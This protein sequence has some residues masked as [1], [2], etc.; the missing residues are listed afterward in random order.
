MLR[1][2]DPLPATLLLLLLL[3]APALHPGLLAAQ[4]WEVEGEVGA[5]VFFGNTDQVNVMTRAAVERGDSILEFSGDAGFNYGEATDSDGLSSV[6]KRSWV[7]RVNLDYRPLARVS[8]FFFAMVESS[9]EKRLALRHSS[10]LGGKVLLVRSEQS[11]VDLSVSMLAERTRPRGEINR[12]DDRTLA[13]WSARFRIRR[14]FG[15]ERMTF[16]SENSYQPV[17]NTLNDYTFS[18]KNSLSYELTRVIA[19]RLSFVDNY[20]SGA[21]TRGARTNNDGQLIFSVLSRF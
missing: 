18:S 7:S 13:R 12:E 21:R 4:E 20:D 2:S 5:S 1:I 3:A 11:R 6:N 9:Y 19:L 10:G 8:P 14:T 15:D 17:F 16:N